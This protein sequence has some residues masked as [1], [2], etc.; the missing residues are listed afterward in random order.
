MIILIWAQDE[1]GGIAKEGAIP[2]HVKD[3]LKM[4]KKITKNKIVVM[5]YKTY[6]SIGNPLPERKNIVLSSNHKIDNKDVITLTTI[7][8]ILKLCGNRDLYIIGGRQIYE[9]FF[10]LANRLIISKIKG[11]FNCDLFTDFIDLKTFNFVGKK[12]YEEFIVEIYDKKL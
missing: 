12:E 8:E 3:D 6:E 5:G 1:R 2:W 9:L 11:D 10:P 4:F 7:D